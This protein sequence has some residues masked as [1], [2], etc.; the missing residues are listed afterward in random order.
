MILH[1]AKKEI[2]ENVVTY[3][4]LLVT[5]LLA[6][7]IVISLLVSYGDFEMQVEHYALNRPNPGS[8]NV[9]LPPNP[10]SIFAKGAEADLDRLFWVHPGSVEMES[11]Q[12]SINR[13]F[14]LFTV[15]DMLFI[16]KVM[17]S[18]IA[19]LLTFDA[20]TG[21]KENGTL[22]L[23]LAGGSSRSDMLLGKFAGRLLL[24][25]L[26]FSVLF[27]IAAAVVS[28]L[29]DVGSSGYFWQRAF[30]ILLAS[31][32]YA[33]VFSSLGILLS[34]FAHQSSAS[35]IVCLTAWVALVFVVPQAGA[36]LAR[37]VSDIPPSERVNL[38]RSLNQVRAEYGRF[39]REK[40]SGRGKELGA[41]YREQNEANSRLLESYIPKL[42][43][44]VNRTKNL[45]RLSP[46]GAATF[47]LTD[48]ANTGIYEEHRLKDALTSYMERNFDILSDAVDGS[49]ES[50]QYERASLNEI[51]A[52][53]ALTDIVILAIAGIGFTGAAMM[54]FSRYDAR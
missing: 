6:V 7:L 47:L 38:E 41:Y 49:V 27:L 36:A 30:T 46:A 54:R 17:L 16:V 44:L 53:S 25:V 10:L 3:R 19:L 35:L 37:S 23:A 24:V 51:L 39:Q 50:F 21:E 15:P 31:L 34:S 2:L 28:M 32:L 13:L 4:F 52:T 33:G 14:A 20:I 5:S 11:S 26:P 12:Q 1:F 22:K 48:V 8:A 18:L 42:E 29:P 40:V 45:V 9:M 43:G